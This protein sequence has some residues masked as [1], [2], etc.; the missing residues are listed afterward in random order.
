[1][2]NYLNELLFSQ[3]WYTMKLVNSCSVHGLIHELLLWTSGFDPRVVH[4]GCVVE[5][6]AH[7]HFFSDYFKFLQLIAILLMIYIVLSVIFGMVNRTFRGCSSNRCTV[8]PP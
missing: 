1:M 2:G 6:M 8:I 5:I 7:G 3:D 4:V